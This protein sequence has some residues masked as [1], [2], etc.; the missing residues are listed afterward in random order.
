LLV[1]TTLVDVEAEAEAEA[2]PVEAAEGV[3]DA[4][5]VTDLSDIYISF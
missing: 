2:V 1:A 5:V 3:E 4:L